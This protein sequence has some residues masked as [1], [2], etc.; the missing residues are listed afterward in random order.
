MHDRSMVRQP[1][2]QYTR[3]VMAGLLA[4]ALCVLAAASSNASAHGSVTADADQC[5]LRIGF[6][7]A[8]FK[9]YQPVASGYREFC[10]DLPATG[11]TVFVM[12]YLHDF[13]GS[14]PLDFRIVSNPTGLGR[15]TQLEDLPDDLLALSVVHSGPAVV[16]DVLMLRHEFAERGDYVGIVTA[17]HPQTREQ[18][19]AVFPFRVGGSS[20]GVVPWLLGLIVLAQLGYWWSRGSLVRW[21]RAWS[22]RIALLVLLPAATD[23]GRAAEGW[24]E[25]ESGAFRVQVLP[26]QQPLPLNVMHV[27]TLEVQTAAGQLFSAAELQLEGGMPAHDHGLPSAPQ[28]LQDTAPGRYRIEGLRFHMQGDWVLWLTIRYEGREDRV[29][30][31]VRL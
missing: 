15:Y 11:E 30:I 29:R 18:Y 28:V 31:P 3:P 25:S 5:I 8:H 22:A 4:L 20:W 1:D 23:D 10:E 16:P 26:G 24:L 17:R 12:E 21:Q 19:L 27:W 9:I 7:T 13:L 6:Y 2:K 14:V